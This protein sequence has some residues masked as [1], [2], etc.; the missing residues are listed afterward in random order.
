MVL[1]KWWICATPA[2]IRC[3]WCANCVINVMS[4][5][6]RLKW[7]TEIR[8]YFGYKV[9]NTKKCNIH[10][11]KNLATRFCSSAALQY[12]NITMH[13]THREVFFQ[14]LWNQNRHSVLTQKGTV[15]SLI[16]NAKY[17][18]LSHSPVRTKALSCLSTWEQSNTDSK[19][20]WKH[21]K[22]ICSLQS[23]RAPKKMLNFVGCSWLLF[24]I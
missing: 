20:H 18:K 16:L 17:L 19:S 2:F 1:E 21:T 14:L 7:Q 24:R 13:N 3:F 10:T 22:P 5:F 6:V 8:I 11:N 15:L 23:R 12:E 4:L 9:L